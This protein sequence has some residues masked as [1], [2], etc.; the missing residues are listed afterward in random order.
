METQGF[1][2][3]PNLILRNVNRTSHI[4]CLYLQRRTS[5][6]ANMLRPEWGFDDEKTKPPQLKSVRR[7]HARAEL[8]KVLQ[9]SQRRSS[10]RAED[11]ARFSELELGKRK[12]ELPGC[13]G[14]SKA[15]WFTWASSS[16]PRTNLNL[17][18]NFGNLKFGPRR[19]RFQS[20]LWNAP[21][22]ANKCIER[23]RVVQATFRIRIES[24][25][26]FNAIKLI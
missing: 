22:I 12:H 7:F 13:A 16:M 2:I 9:I 24:Y 6:L 8:R 23:E 11:D 19:R 4:L 25:K 20:T 21:S 14:D 10:I 26:I 15:R 3:V 5:S 17:N 18:S 1:R